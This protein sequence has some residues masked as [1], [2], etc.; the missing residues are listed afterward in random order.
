[1]TLEFKFQLLPNTEML[2]VPYGVPRPAVCDVLKVRALHRGTVIEGLS[3]GTCTF[4][5]EFKTEDKRRP[6]LSIY[7]EL[8]AVTGL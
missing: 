6:D 2:S 8:Q 3:M 5:S 7:R 4:A 1:M